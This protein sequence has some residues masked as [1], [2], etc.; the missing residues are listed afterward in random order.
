MICCFRYNY[1]LPDAWWSHYAL[2][3]CSAAG[4][5]A[6]KI[7]KKFHVSVALLFFWRVCNGIYV[8]AWYDNHFQGISK[9]K[10]FMSRYYGAYGTIWILF[11]ALVLYFL[12]K[13]FRKMRSVFPAL[14]VINAL[15]II[16]QALAGKPFLERAGFF[17]NGTISGLFIAFTIP[18]SLA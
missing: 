11:I 5:F 17:M 18:S 8:F 6:Y 16:G 2:A 10:L 13:D 1:I 7:Y 15:Y 3:M 4:F 12:R 14:G 9:T